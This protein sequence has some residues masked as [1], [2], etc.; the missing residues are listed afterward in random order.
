MADTRRK[1]ALD[2]G[3]YSELQKAAT[4]EHRTLAGMVRFLLDAHATIL[5]K[6]R[7]IEKRIARLE[8]RVRI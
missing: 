3:L 1:I 2:L 6:Q 8:K 4:K 5:P 7:A